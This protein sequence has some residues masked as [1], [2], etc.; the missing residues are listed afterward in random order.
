MAQ[1]YRLS[2][3]AN[4]Q[5][6]P[7]TKSTGDVLFFVNVAG[8]N[9]AD[10][11]GQWSVGCRLEKDRYGRQVCRH[12]FTLEGDSAGEVRAAEGQVAA[13]VTPAD[14]NQG[15]V[16]VA[17]GYGDRLA[18]LR[19][20]RHPRDGQAQAGLYRR[21]LKTVNVVRAAFAEVVAY[22][23]DILLGLRGGEAEVAVGPA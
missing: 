21:E 11:S 7:D 5:V 16:A 23:Q 2:R 3:A 12:V 14:G 13:E 9:I 4:Q 18:L 17:P 6:D 20:A 8:T 10:F 1:V 15:R 19:I 22:R